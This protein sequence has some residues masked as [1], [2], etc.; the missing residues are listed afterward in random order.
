MPPQ[1]KKTTTKKKVDP[2][3]A[4]MKELEEELVDMVDDDIKEKIEA[5]QKAKEIR[6]KR[7][8][9]ALPNQIKEMKKRKKYLKEQLAAR[10]N[11]DPLDP[12]MAKKYKEKVEYERLI[13][14]H[15]KEMVEVYQRYQR[16]K[17]GLL[18]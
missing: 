8:K 9:R 17:A 13:K 3:E 12:T 16:L 14:K 2:L 10:E 1:S 18:D 11:A 7:A 15:D 4:A 5:D 6:I